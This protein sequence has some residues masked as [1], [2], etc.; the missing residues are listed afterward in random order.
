MK[1]GGILGPLKT[2]P[3]ND[4]SGEERLLDCE[5]VEKLLIRARQVRCR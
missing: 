3:R 5:P 1:T 4:Q 2:P